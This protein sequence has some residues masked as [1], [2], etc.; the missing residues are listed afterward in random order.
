MGIRSP[1][2]FIAGSELKHLIRDAPGTSHSCRCLRTI[3]LG[4]SSSIFMARDS[5]FSASNPAGKVLPAKSPGTM[6][7]Q[8]SGEWSR[9]AQFRTD[10]LS[11][12]GGASNQLARIKLVD[13]FKI[14]RKQHFFS[15]SGDRQTW[16]IMYATP[17]FVRNNR[18]ST[19]CK[20]LY[21]QYVNSGARRRVILSSSRVA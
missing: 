16:Q 10:V 1:V 21:N 5:E 8:S 3:S 9:F 12:T 14:E 20:L 15:F 13:T 6:K 7:P 17:E 19:L 4:P 2:H 11:D 18:E